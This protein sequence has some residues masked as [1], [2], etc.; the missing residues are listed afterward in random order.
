LGLVAAA[1][2][3]VDLA[4]VVAVSTEGAAGG[5]IAAVAMEYFYLEEEAPVVAVELYSERHA[6]F[7]HGLQLVV[8]EFAVPVARSC[9]L[10]AVVAVVVGP[11][12]SQGIAA[13]AYF[14]PVHVGLVPVIAAGGALEY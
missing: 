4:A 3:A 5:S 7:E 8:E 11:V 9:S 1:A 14:V 2:A 6:C 12:A 13:V 10:V